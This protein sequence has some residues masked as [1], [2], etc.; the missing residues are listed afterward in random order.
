MHGTD[1]YIDLDDSRDGNEEM[2]PY[3]ILMT[4]AAACGGFLFGYDTGVVSGAM[5]KIQSE[6]D[7]TNVQEEVVVSSTIAAAVLSA[8]FGGKF[9]QKYG[10]R[11]VLLF[12]AFT[13]SLGA[14]VLGFAQNYQSLVFG[15]LIVGLGIGLASLTSPVYIAEAAPI[16]L[17]GKL[18]TLNTLLITCGQFVAG[19]I[20]G[21]LSEKEGGW[22]WM[23][24]L[25]GIPAV[26]MG[27][28]FI[29]LPESPRWLFYN[30]NLVKAENVLKKI[31][32][33][34]DVSDEIEDISKAKNKDDSQNYG[35]KDLVKDKPVIKALML[36]CGLQAVNQLV[37][38]N[39]VMYYSATIYSMAGFSESAS[40]WLAGFTALAQSL[41]VVSGLI[42][43]EKKGRRFLIL[44]SL[45][46]VTL[47]LISL[48]L[49]FYLQQMFSP[50]AVPGTDAID[51]KCSYFDNVFSGEVVVDSCFLCLQLDKCGY[52][53]DTQTCWA[54][55]DGG[56]DV[57]GRCSDSMW[58]ETSCGNGLLGWL[59]VLC[60]VA[61]LLFFGIGL[62]S[63]PWTVNAEI[64]PQRARSLGTS[65][66]TSVNWAG[67]VIVS[68]TFLSIA[69]PSVLSECGA[70]WLY[71]AIA[72]LSWIWISSVMPETAGLSLEEIET[73]F[74][75]KESVKSG[76]TVRL[77]T[78][79]GS[80]QD[81]NAYKNQAK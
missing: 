58:E 78:E 36:G 72:V 68:A 45:F 57:L 55:S 31:R 54:A 11:P 50:Y 6:L 15:R 33:K 73:L 29:F 43:I 27:L 30:G 10:R 40:I 18:L 42:L 56:S 49:S 1:I 17:R 61:Y 32:G 77:Q 9:S 39:T 3:V 59:A 12:A 75:D 63:I 46:L 35:V 51:E 79:N 13:F 69:S 52:C 16:H 70:F 60:M 20:D 48:G 41:G 44:V 25:S 28:A 64:Y 7:L 34:S 4:M 22:R 23:L 53:R 21:I 74:T 80:E 47:S 14:F 24:G 76:D 71:A 67:N 62:S 81:G 38:I 8:A 37:G 5:L 26:L 66:A 2:T 19:M 65:I